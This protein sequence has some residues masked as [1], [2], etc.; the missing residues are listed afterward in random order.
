MSNLKIEIK[1]KICILS[2]NRVKNLNA[3]N[4]DLLFKLKE[5][6]LKYHDSKEIR[7]IILTGRGEQ[8]FIAG[9][10][11]KSM[12]KMSSQEAYDFSRLGNDITL[13][14]DQ[15]PKPIIA[16]INGYA[17]GGGCEF[18]MACHI[19]FASENAVIGQPETGLG[20]IPGFGG[21]QRLPRI[22]GLTN[23]YNLLLSGGSI[24]ALEAK[25]IGLVSDVFKKTE[26]IEKTMKFAEKINRN[27]PFS[28]KMIIEAVN[29]G[30]HL[31]LREAL[32][33]ESQ[34]FKKVFENENKNI[35]IESFLSKKNPE[36]ID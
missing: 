22:V 12:S 33:L 16:A 13:I 29:K 21:T 6:L 34:Y 2:I 24:D 26:L 36:F 4:L 30:V 25:R 23:A 31:D 11:I 7:T 14:M 8:A 10:D 15:Y 28:S 27:S 35:G 9:A 1:N 20:L 19:R 18:A 5:S 32:E 3:I 17:L